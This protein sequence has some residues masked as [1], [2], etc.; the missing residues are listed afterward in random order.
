MKLINFFIFLLIASSLSSCIEEIDL[1]LKEQ[2]QEQL[3]VEGMI[4]T[5]TTAHIV[6]LSKTAPYFS[7]KPAERASGADVTITDDFGNVFQLEEYDPGIYKT[8]TD[9]YGI[10]GHTY[11]LNIKFGGETYSAQSTMK[12][13][14]VIDSLGY[15]WNPQREQYIILLYGQEPEGKGDNYMWHV[16]KNGQHVTDTIDKVLFIDDELFDGAYIMGFKI[17]H[18]I[19]DYNIQKG[20]TVRVDTHSIPH[21]ALLFFTGVLNESHYSWSPIDTPPANIKGNISNEAIGLFFA[22]GISRNTVII[23]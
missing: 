8:G 14:P 5:D 3:V 10:I 16:Y 6:K 19:Y 18:W 15:V 23:E 17:E 13:V 2:D 11:N 7:Q 20:D 21:D 12:R 4:T 22:S 1:I 9:V